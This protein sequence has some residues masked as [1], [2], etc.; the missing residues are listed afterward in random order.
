MYSFL[1]PPLSTHLSLLFETQN[2]H[3]SSNSSKLCNLITWY[4]CLICEI[5]QLSPHRSTGFSNVSDS[6]DN[7]A[8]DTSLQ[9]VA[10]ALVYLHKTTTSELRIRFK[11]PHLALCLTALVRAVHNSL[12]IQTHFP[13]PKCSSASEQNMDCNPIYNCMLQTDP[14]NSSFGISL[15]EKWLFIFVEYSMKQV[16]VFDSDTSSWQGIRHTLNTTHFTTLL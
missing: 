2:C 16:G 8:C 7:T 15:F 13:A 4:I 10:A 11:S 3:Q 14:V 6:P 5:L 12:E 1:C 9:R